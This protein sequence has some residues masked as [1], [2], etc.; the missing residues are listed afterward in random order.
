MLSPL[1]APQDELAA[2]NAKIAELQLII[3]AA[4]AKNAEQQ[5]WLN[6]E[7]NAKENELTML[8][9]ELDDKKDSE[10]ADMKYARDL[11]GRL[12]NSGVILTRT[13]D[14]LESASGSC[15][16]ALSLNVLYT[17]IESTSHDSATAP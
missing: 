5:E 9:Q 10:V 8:R 1:F 3:A 7:L 4:N 15:P 13:W 16:L 2:A 17:A 14:D 12:E 6:E 11:W